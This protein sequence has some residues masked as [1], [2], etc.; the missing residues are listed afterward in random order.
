M[1]F[2][3]HRST[4]PVVTL[5]QSPETGNSNT[6]LGLLPGSMHTTTQ[7]IDDKVMT[8]I[9]KM[10]KLLSCLSYCFGPLGI[11][12]CLITLSYHAT[13]CTRSGTSHP[14]RQVL[15][16][17]NWDPC[18]GLVRRLAYISFVPL[19]MILSS[20]LSTRSLVQ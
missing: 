6:P 9:P 2:S 14:V 12:L 13:V 1:Y 18:H 16:Y 3:P 20:P 4:H 8:T 5:F 11:C 7:L 10:T 15:S 17:T 19:W